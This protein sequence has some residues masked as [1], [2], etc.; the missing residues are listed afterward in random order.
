VAAAASQRDRRGC[1]A[2]D[3]STVHP[4]WAAQVEALG[5]GDVADEAWLADL[6]ERSTAGQ[7]QRL[8]PVVS[9]IVLL[10]ELGTLPTIVPPPGG[11][12]SAW[13]RC[14]ERGR[15]D[16][17][18]LAKVRA[19]LAQAE[20]TTF[21]AEAET[22]TAKAQQLIARHAIDAAI[23]WSRTGRTHRP[24][25][26]ARGDATFGQL[27]RSPVRRSYDGLGWHRGV[28][29]ADRAKLQADLPAAGAEEAPSGR[30]AGADA[31]GGGDRFA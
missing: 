1:R 29:A 26:V 11:D 23:V 10:A 25:T 9:A 4:Q 3:P 24:V 22:F 17:P 31:A 13:S 7:R 16:D 2:D 15:P 14:A 18:V 20:S 8:D 19:L 30:D 27:I 21:E 6:I 12:P 5:V 28:L